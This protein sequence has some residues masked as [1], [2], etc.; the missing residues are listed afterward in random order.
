[1]RADLLSEKAA[2]IELGPK[3]QTLLQQ[4]QSTREAAA[5]VQDHLNKKYA[6]LS[7]PGFCRFVNFMII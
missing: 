5:Q 3:N 2:D 7:Y 1:M 6:E 4:A